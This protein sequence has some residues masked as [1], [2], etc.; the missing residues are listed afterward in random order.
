MMGA[1]AGIVFLVMFSKGQFDPVSL[2][3]ALALIVLGSLLRHRARRM[4]PHSSQRGRL[5]RRMLGKDDPQD[6]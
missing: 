3:I 4:H 2:G 5:L 1:I 6:L